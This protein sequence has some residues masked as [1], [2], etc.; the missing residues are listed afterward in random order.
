MW[1]GLF[2]CARS[3]TRRDI[4]SVAVAWS[5]YGLS[6]SIRVYRPQQVCSGVIWYQW[7]W[8]GFSGCDMISTGLAWPQWVWDINS[9]FV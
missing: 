2:V 3:T 6:G 8:H 1:H 5:G 4:A 9:G 7:L